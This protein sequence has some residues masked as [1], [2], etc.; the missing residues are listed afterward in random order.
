M[1]RARQD[2]EPFTDSNHRSGDFFL[3]CCLMEADTEKIQAI[4]SVII[5]WEDRRPR[6]SRQT[7][8]LPVS[9]TT[10]GFNM[11]NNRITHNDDG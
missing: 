2:S 11:P 1:L 3:A 6:L 9:T 10:I 4:P 5:I 8:I 7:G